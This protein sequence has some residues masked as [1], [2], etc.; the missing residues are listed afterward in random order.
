MER[1]YTKNGRPLKV[2]RQDLFSRS[3]KHVARMRDG[4]AYG[5][6]GRYVGTIVNDDRLIYRTT[7]SA[8]ISSPFAPRASA[9][10]AYANHAAT[11]AWGEEPPIPD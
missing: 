2:S 8:S 3:G 9:G 1:I 4:K 10:H 6:D 7:N 11:A 5:P